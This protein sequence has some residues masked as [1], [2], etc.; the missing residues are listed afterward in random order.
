VATGEPDCAISCRALNGPEYDMHWP[1]RIGT[2][3]AAV[4]ATPSSRHLAF[5]TSTQIVASVVPA[6]TVNPV[7]VPVSV[8]D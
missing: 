8:I 5:A 2:P 1:D 4:G 6:G 3:V 7:A